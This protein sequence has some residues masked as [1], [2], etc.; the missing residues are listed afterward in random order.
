MCCGRFGGRLS[1]C[2]AAWRYSLDM[3]NID[4]IAACILACFAVTVSGAVCQERGV[5]FGLGFPVT[6]G[7]TF[8]SSH[9]GKS[10][11]QVGYSQPVFGSAVLRPSVSFDRYLNPRMITSQVYS[12]RVAIGLPFDINRSVSVVPEIGGGYTRMSFQVGGLPEPIYYNFDGFHTWVS[13][14]ALICLTEAVCM[15]PYL[16]Y[17]AVFLEQIENVDDSG[18]NRQLHSVAPGVSIEARF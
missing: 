14:R 10:A 2:Y 11:I 6:V 9:D 8:M 5:F 15:G 13:L 18:Y 17:H 16:G 7:D 1:E 12:A 4:L 3:K